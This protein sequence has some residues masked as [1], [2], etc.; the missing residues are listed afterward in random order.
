M[1]L[2]ARRSVGVKKGMDL[3][4]GA[5]RVGR[6]G[7]ERHGDRGLRSANATATA[8]STSSSLSVTQCNLLDD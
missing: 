7:L 1:I 8:T 6:L 5:N 3:E 2:I 4:E